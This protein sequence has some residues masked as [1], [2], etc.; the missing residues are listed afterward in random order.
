MNLS[1]EKIEALV[2]FLKIT[3]ERE[4][5]CNECLEYV[6]E[7]ADLEL[8]G[9]KIPEALEAVE[10][11]LSICAECREEYEVLQLALKE[12]DSDAGSDG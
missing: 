8:S 2:G 10:H 5:N 6:A 1:S 11:H 12:M 4:L 9:V 3:R 7:L